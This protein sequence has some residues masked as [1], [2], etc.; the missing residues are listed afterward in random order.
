M[1][2]SDG[3]RAKPLRR[4]AASLGWLA[5]SSVQ[6]RK[7][8]AIEGVSGTS[9]VSLRS[10]LASKQQ[11]AAATRSGALDP[12]ELRA[13]RKGR[14]VLSQSNPGVTS[15]DARDRADLPATPGDVLAASRAALE[16]KAALYERLAAGEDSAGG[17][18]E[19]DFALKAPDTARLAV[20]GGLV[21]RD[22][23]AERDRRAWEE[24]VEANHAQESE[25]EAR[26]RSRID[27][28]KELMAETAEGRMA[29]QGARAAS[30]QAAAS[31]AAVLKA[32][33]L[34]RQ[35]EARRAK[36]AASGSKGG[37][38]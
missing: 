28:V 26:R 34:K 36:K 23:L 25:A 33:F 16:R 20:A 2:M 13:R 14:D 18:Y 22:M 7:R 3:D 11:E 37:V 9:L 29:A 31:K 35:V 38:T 21:S 32:A 8:T 15:R 4:D 12:E 6:P 27:A 5:Q 19:V 24:E 17:E 1:R 30:Q 10:Q